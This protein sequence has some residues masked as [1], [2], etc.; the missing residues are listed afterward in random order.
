MD[1]ISDMLIRV[2]NAGLARKESALVPYSNIKMEIANLL[3]REGFVKGAHKRTRQGKKMIEVVLKYNK[4]GLH[5]V[6]DVSRISKPSR[7]IYYGLAKV[8]PVKYGYG[9][10][11]LST[12]SGVMTGRE[13]R[14]AGVGGEA[15]FKI[16]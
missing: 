2:K 1:P 4:S 10:L 14:K 6:N 3:V 13:A 11:V 7:R 12:P 9:R 15:M 8:H 16:W 5:S